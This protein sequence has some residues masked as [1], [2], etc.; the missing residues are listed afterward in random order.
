MHAINPIS[1]PPALHK[2]VARA[3]AQPEEAGAASLAGASAAPLANPAV[4]YDM[5]LG[6]V[7]V[8]FFNDA[9]EL[10]NSAPSPRQLKAYEA[11]LNA[12]PA[13][14][15]QRDQHSEE[16]ALDGIAVVA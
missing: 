3:A 11:R 10:A 16:G 4:R 15:P 14:T 7:V 9:G 6:V 13:P 8:E 12:T 2:G 5:K 1:A